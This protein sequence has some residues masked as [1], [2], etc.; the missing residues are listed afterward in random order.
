MISDI[1]DVTK[2]MAIVLKQLRENK[3]I[4]SMFKKKKDKVFKYFIT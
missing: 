4:L 3:G 1:I 2:H